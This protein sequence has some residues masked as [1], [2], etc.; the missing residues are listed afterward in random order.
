MGL[1]AKQ[2][3]SHSFEPAPAG[4]HLARCVRVIDLGTQHN[5]KFGNTKHQVLVFWELPTEL[6]GDAP[7]IVWR[8][9]T[10]SIHD[11]AILGK[12]L[13]SWRGRPFDPAE[14]E[15][16]EL[17]NIVGKPCMVTVV[18]NT[19]ETTSGKTTYANV[20]SVAGVIKGMQVPDQ[21][22]P[23]VIYDMDNH[24]QDVFDALPEYIQN[25]IAKSEERAGTPQERDSVADQFEAE[26]PP[27]D[28]PF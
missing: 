28:V 26:A 1:V 11:K 17:K 7:F 14:L 27:D 18:H 16:F 25:T 23:S 2:G 19:K 21:I 6:D 20:N 13:A 22:H 8:R 9:Y 4:T 12:H 10:C 5:E 24:D 15:G 3:A